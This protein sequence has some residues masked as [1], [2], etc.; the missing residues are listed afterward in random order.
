MM[1]WLIL[2]D[3]E[4]DFPN[5]ETP[6]KVMTTRDYLTRPN[7]FQG[8]RPKIVNLS[9][10][11]AYQGSGYYC[12]LLAEARRHRIVPTVETML[13]LSRR[14]LYAQSLPD[15]EEELNAAVKRGWQAGAEPRRVFICFGRAIEPALAPFARLIFD[16]Y[17]TPILEVSVEPGEWVRI[18]RIRAVPCTE[19]RGEEVEFMRESLAQH[20]RGNWRDPRERVPARYSIAVLHDPQE[21]L[22]PTNLESLK[23]MARF[24]SKMGVEFEP[25][26]KKDLSR[27]AEFDA[28]FIRETTSIDNHTYRFARRAV[29]EGM[30][31][32]DDPVS[33]MRCTNKVYLTELLRANG[34]PVPH[35]LVVDS[36]KDIAKIEE[37]IGYPVVVKI[38]DGSF[39][40]GVKKV[41]DREELQEVLTKMLADSNLILVQE[42]MPTSFDWRIGVLD[43]QPLFACHYRMAKKHWQIVKHNADGGAEEGS[44][45]TFAL[46]EVPPEVIDAATRAAR[47]IG[48]GLYGVD[49]KQND[50]GVFIIEIN[51]N[52]NLDHNVEDAAGKTEVW[53][54]VVEWFIDRIE[55]R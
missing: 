13:E 39:S 17:R 53:R 52:P 33:M 32:I 18:R 41:D 12:S 8:T 30:P 7:L 42:F 11:Y 20:T 28:L 21:Q 35:T 43:G 22:P 55:R 1:G 24:A 40:R 47:L 45:K 54:R 37:E 23:Y 46:E 6:H 2:V 31:V 15:L 44:S 4:K 14:E 36:V 25:I 38:P 49:L 50:N 27:L 10:S 5:Y 3:Q 16:W 34:L 48:R 26:T 9:R 29:Q 51:D 19:L